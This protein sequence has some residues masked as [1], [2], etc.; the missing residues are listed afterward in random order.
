M[1]VRHINELIGT[2]QDVNTKTWNSRRLLLKQDGMGFSLH[3]T[4]IKAGT[5]TLIWYT[6]HLEAVYCIEGEGEI[7]VI[8][9]QTYAIRPGTVY[10]LDG[11]EKHMLRAHTEMRMVCVF[12]PPLTGREVH[13]QNGSYPLVQEDDPYPSRVFSEPRL[14]PRRDPVVYSD[15]KDSGPLTEEQVAFYETN[16]YLFLEQFFTPEEV[17]DYRQEMKRLWQESRGSAAEEII[18]E[19]DSEEIRSIFA[20]HRNNPVFEGLSRHPKLQ[21]I[22][23]YLLG[24]EVYVHQS[25]INFK[26][27]FNGKEFYWHSDFETWHVEDGMPR[28]RALSCSIA[29]EDN[30][31]YNGPLMV[32]PGSHKTFVSCVGHTPE[33]HYKQSLKRQEYG[34]P[35]PDS[36]TRL[37]EEGG[38]AAPV[39]KAGSILI[40]DCNLMHGS[41][42]NITP[43]PR[44]NVFMVFNSV[45]NRLRSPYSGQKRR[46]WYL[47][48]R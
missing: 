23:Q 5:E 12:N 8:G 47:A 9:G 14:L 43:K 42:G 39:G 4:I 17:E 11:H 16:G 27:G 10:A 28:M 41:N 7:E 15:C 2:D 30:Y 6:N 22:V 38:I 29:L 40:F 19:P 21:A 24:G 32:V 33:N 34:V 20:V 35:D 36:L 44:S 3:D 48:D 26:P 1:I 18:L 37:I 25:R 45:E 13:D 46:P 31:S